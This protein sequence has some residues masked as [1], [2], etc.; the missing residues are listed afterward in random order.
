MKIN[1]VSTLII[2]MTAFINLGFQL[3]AGILDGILIF[4]SSKY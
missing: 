4:S 1:E 2:C 3:S